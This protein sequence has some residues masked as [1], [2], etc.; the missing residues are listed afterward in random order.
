MELEIDENGKTFE[1]NALIKAR[2]IAKMTNM[3]TIS[4][5]S[6]LEVDAIGKKPGIYSARYAGEN[7]T[8][9]ENREKLLKVFKKY[10]CKPKK[11]KI[12][13]LL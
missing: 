10:T 3:I 2:T 13:L 5:D 6:G 8:D 4:D 7:A 1:H 11:C 9:E 12:C